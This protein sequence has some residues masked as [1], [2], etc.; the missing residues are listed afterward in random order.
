MEHK[1]AA[2]LSWCTSKGIEIDPR[3]HIAPDATGLAVYSGAALIEPSQTS[4]DIIISIHDPQLISPL[5]HALV[6]RIP[7]KAVLSVKSCSA[8]R[9]I[10]SRPYGLDAQLALS[11][12]LLIEIQRGTSSPWYGYLQ[13]FPDSIVDLPIFWD[14]EIEGRSLQDGL[15]ALGWL[16]GTEVQKLLS[17]TDG[18]PLIESIRNYFDEIVIPTTARCSIAKPTFHQFAWAYSLVSSR[19]F[20]V[21]AYHGLSMVPIADAFNH[22]YD[23]HTEYEVCPECGSLQQCPHDRDAEL[24]LISKASNDAPVE[25]DHTYDMVSNT[26]I[27]AYSEIFNTY[28]ETLSNAQLLTQYGFTLDVNE[29]DRIMWGFDELVHLLEAEV[30]SASRPRKSVGF[31]WDEL[32]AA[33]DKSILSESELIFE[34]FDTA[35]CINCEGRVSWQLWLVV[36]SHVC[37]QVVGSADEIFDLSHKLAQYQIQ[38]ENEEEEV[39]SRSSDSGSLARD[40]ATTIVN[41]CQQ[42]KDRLGVGTDEEHPGNLID[43]RSLSWSSHVAPKIFHLQ[44]LESSQPRTKS[45]LLQVIT[46]LSILNSCASAWQEGE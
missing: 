16:K 2:L 19:A 45:A 21:D 23:H 6:V 11:L 3:I 24:P 10:E 32:E 5:T 40:I 8:S 33:F 17:G 1:I 46:E 38:Q 15:E 18:T 37:A 28:G 7:P 36:T 12:A 43:V 35:F 31:T 26:A 27:P 25:V 14:L 30:S 9:I 39:N 13:S 20:L 44:E 41:L 42:R 34:P 22:T 29:N 4:E